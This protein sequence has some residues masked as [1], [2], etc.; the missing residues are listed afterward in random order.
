M[1]A[2]KNWSFEELRFQDYTQG[3]KTAVPTNT[4]GAGFGT[5]QQPQQNAFGGF[6][7]TANSNQPGT[8]NQTQPQAGIFGNAA[9]A[10]GN[11]FGMPAPSNNIFGQPAAPTTNAF[12]QTQSK[13]TLPGLICVSLSHS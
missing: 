6:N 7:A 12:G 9:P 13:S 8:F 4:I 11:A 2:Y 10:A 1:D 3:R 5:Q